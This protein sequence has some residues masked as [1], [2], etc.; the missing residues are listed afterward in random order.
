MKSN[1]TYTPDPINKRIKNKDISEDYVHCPNY[2]VK[3]LF[4]VIYY[5]LFGAFSKASL[6]WKLEAYLQ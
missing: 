4:L 2:F 1:I 6:F 3:F 5:S